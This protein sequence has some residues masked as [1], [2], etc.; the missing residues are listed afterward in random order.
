M[1]VMSEAMWKKAMPYIL[2]EVLA[3]AGSV[4]TLCLSSRSSA[5]YL[6]APENIAASQD[7]RERMTE[8][9]LLRFLF[10]YIMQ[11]VGLD[12]S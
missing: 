3:F 5:V 9:F 2:S 7:S 6:A 1:G 8:D 10:P 11:A 4:G 12:G